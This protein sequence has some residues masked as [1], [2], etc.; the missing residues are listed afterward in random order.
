M[1]RQTPPGA[2]ARDVVTEGGSRVLQGAKYATLQPDVV[3]ELRSS[4]RVSSPEELLDP[5]AIE[6]L[7][8]EVERQLEHTLRPTVLIDLSAPIRCTLIGRAALRD[9]AHW[10]APR[11]ARSC[12]L[13]ST[14]RMRGA[15]LLAVHDGSDDAAVVLTMSEAERWLTSTEGRLASALHTLKETS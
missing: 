1:S 9:F 5:D 3:K 13:V 7:R 14:P 4:I 8:A 12:Y 2:G 15:A 11:A 10:L 6:R